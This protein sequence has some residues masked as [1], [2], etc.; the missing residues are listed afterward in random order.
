MNWCICNKGKR[1]LIYRVSFFINK[2]FEKS[3]YRGRKLSSIMN[4]QNSL[5]IQSKISYTMF[6]S[7]NHYNN[8]TI[9]KRNLP[10]Y[11]ILFR[12]L[13]YQ[14]NIYKNKERDS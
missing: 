9:N 3:K 1:I 10:R 4:L 8:L 12:E 5:F 6:A 7:A 14:Y 2:L 11:R 13:K